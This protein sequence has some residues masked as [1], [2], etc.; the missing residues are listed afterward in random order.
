MPGN[1]TGGQP[2]LANV[3]TASGLLAECLRALK[4]LDV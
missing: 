2:E 3:L 1:P 4:D